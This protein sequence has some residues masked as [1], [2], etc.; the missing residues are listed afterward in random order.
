MVTFAAWF[1]FR[2]VRVSVGGGVSSGGAKDQKSALDQVQP[3]V[4]K[5]VAVTTN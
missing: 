1:A 3:F 5:V 2:D 4:R